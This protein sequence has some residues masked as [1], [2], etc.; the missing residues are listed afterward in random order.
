MIINNPKPFRLRNQL[1]SEYLVRM[2]IGMECEYT[3]EHIKY[4][5]KEPKLYIIY[6]RDRGD[7]TI[8]S[9]LYHHMVFKF[10]DPFDVPRI[11]AEVFKNYL[12]V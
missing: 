5:H 8:S 10:N 12:G 9:G 4:T 11:I 7:V 6:G 1:I 3:D 2:L